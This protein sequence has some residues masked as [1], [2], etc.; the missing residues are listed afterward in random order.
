MESLIVV[1]LE[2]LTQALFQSC[3]SGIIVEIDVF[4]LDGALSHDLLDRIVNPDVR[5]TLF[6]PNP[7]SLAG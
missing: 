3:H 7:L 1:E 4:I 6:S 2:V 5:K